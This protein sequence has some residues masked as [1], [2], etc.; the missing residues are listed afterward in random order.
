MQAN[1]ETNRVEISGRMQEEPL[2][3]HT[4]Y[5]EAFYTFSLA[6]PRLSGVV[7]MLPVTAGERLARA[8]PKAGQTLY[9]A[10]QLRSYNMR[11]N[12]GTRLLLTVFARAIAVLEDEEQA[13]NE[14]VLT[15][16][17]CKP[18]I[19]R[20]TPLSR[21]IADVLLAVN[22]PYHKSDYLPVIVWGRNARF[23][24]GLAVGA[25]I[26]V[27]GRVQSR[28]YQKTLPDGSVA[29]RVAYEVSAAT[30]EPAIS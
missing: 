20:A 14:I 9:V 25:K 8:L 28:E 2:F 16:F 27:Q 3:S 4:L 5:G 15:G 23:V 18:P 11:Q 24:S 26:V 6:A 21:E 1:P 13:I 29:R 7:D 30:V 12:G 19:Y 22:R 17:I 10:G